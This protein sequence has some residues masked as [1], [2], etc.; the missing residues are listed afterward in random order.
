M[1]HGSHLMTY[2]TLHLY[3]IHLTGL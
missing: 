3:N 1:V 2:N